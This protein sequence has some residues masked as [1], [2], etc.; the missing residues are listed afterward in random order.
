MTRLRVRTL[1]PRTEDSGER[2]IAIRA[3]LS[4]LCAIDGHGLVSCST[5]LRG[6]GVIELWGLSAKSI[7]PLNTAHSQRDSLST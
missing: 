4:V 3:C 7:R 1:V 6:I 5:K 2:E